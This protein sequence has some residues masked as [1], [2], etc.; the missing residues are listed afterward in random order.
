MSL[1]VRL[2][3]LSRDCTGALSEMEAVLKASS[4]AN[5]TS[6]DVSPLVASAARGPES[7]ASLDGFDLGVTYM[8][9]GQSP[10]SVSLGVTIVQGDIQGPAGDFSVELR[11]T[12]SASLG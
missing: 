8:I 10:C 2:E 4:V 7:A 5:C 9:T 3:S 11:G 6:S 12:G 1:P